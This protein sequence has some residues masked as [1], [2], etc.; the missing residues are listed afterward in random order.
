M[1]FALEWFKS[2]ALFIGENPARE[3][4]RDTPARMSDALEEL[5]GGYKENPADHFGVI[6]DEPA[7]KDPIAIVFPFVSM[8]EHHVLPFYGDIRLQYQPRDGRIVGLSKIPRGVRCLTGRLQTQERLNA[9]IAEAFFAAV[10]PQWVEVQI[11]ATHLCVSARGVMS[12]AQT[13]TS[14]TR[15]PEAF[16]DHC[17]T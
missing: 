17:H 2:F 14:C 5:L 8:C 15:K 11:T 12:P 16:V 7:A 4:L 9:E 1:P 10:N 6:F 3:G 13:H